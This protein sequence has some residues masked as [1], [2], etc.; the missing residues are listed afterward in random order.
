MQAGMNQLI[1][2]RHLPRYCISLVANTTRYVAQSRLCI[3]SIQLPN[4]NGNTKFS[5]A[6]T[7]CMGCP[8]KSARFNFV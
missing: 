3:L 1:Q 5:L 2:R 7:C 4:G 6:W 8:N